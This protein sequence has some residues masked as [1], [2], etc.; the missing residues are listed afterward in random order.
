MIAPTLHPLEKQRLQILSSLNLLDTPPDPRLEAITESARHQMKV[1]MSAVTILDETHEWY[2]ACYGDIC[3]P[4]GVG[5]R[6]I[7]F[8]GHALLS[9]V[10]FIVEDTL[11]DPRFVDNPMVINPPHIRFY[12]G[13]ALHEQ[14]SHLPIGVFCVKDT[15]PRKLS[16]SEL[17]IFL[18]H[19]KRAESALNNR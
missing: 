4:S 9:E 2:K 13:A 10:L 6:S 8:C 19:W 7:S 18:E 3:P 5:D 1:A 12:A 11:Q 16:E 14:E 17:E 15:K